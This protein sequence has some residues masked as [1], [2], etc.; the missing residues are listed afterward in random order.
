MPGSSVASSVSDS[1]W[2]HELQHARLSCPSLSPG[3]CSNSCPLNRWCHPTILSSVTP[4]SSCPQSFPASGSFPMSLLLAWWGGQSIGASASVLV[5]PMNIQDWFPYLTYFPSPYY[6][7]SNSVSG[8]TITWAQIPRVTLILPFTYSRD[9]HT[10]IFPESGILTLTE[11]K[12]NNNK[13][14]EGIQISRQK[15]IPGKRNSQCQG[16]KMGLCLVY[17]GKGEAGV[18]CSRMSQRE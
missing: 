9:I 2:P 8:T 15:S 6:S 12:L 3:V 18:S 1:L 11:I 14:E 17:A 4:F 10:C 5:L 13:F 16:T 7:S